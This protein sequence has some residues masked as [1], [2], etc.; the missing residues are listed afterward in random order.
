MISQKPVPPNTTL[1]VNEFTSTNVIVELNGKRCKL[2]VEAKTGP[3][4]HVTY[5]ETDK[6]GNVVLSSSTPV[7][8][9]DYGHVTAWKNIET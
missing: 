5:V 4:G 7:H 6:Y 1:R 8:K 9:T 2:V 3:R